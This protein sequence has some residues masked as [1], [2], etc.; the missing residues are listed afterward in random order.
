MAII[1]LWALAKHGGRFANVITLALFGAA[2][3]Y[4]LVFR[5]ASYIHDYYKAFFMP[6]IAIS[7]AAASVYTRHNQR[8]VRLSRPVLDALL[9]MTVAIGLFLLWLLHL[10]GS[11]PGIQAIINSVKAQ[12]E[13]NDRVVVYIEMPGYGTSTGYDRVVEFY[14]YREVEWDVPYQ[15]L[16]NT[17]REQ[18][19]L[20]YLCRAEE[21]NWPEVLLTF[22]HE[23]IYEDTCMLFTIDPQ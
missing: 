15:P 16:I 9:A 4:I 5:N 10:S 23:A 1:G 8:V 17:T 11:Q 21:S 3:L 18:R 12:A 7:A 2:L 19:V 22:P 14:A 20:Y 13:P 6:F